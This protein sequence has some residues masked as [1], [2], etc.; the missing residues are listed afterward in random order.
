VSSFE[1]VV[2]VKA[3]KRNYGWW[4]KLGDTKGGQ[5]AARGSDGF[6]SVVERGD[7]T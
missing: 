3:S 7:D 2:K 6:G 4:R 1:A 5:V